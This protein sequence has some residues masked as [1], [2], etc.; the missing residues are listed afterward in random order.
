MIRQEHD[1]SV[2]DN[3]RCEM[4]PISQQECRGILELKI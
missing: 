1:S 2:K 4:T 3:I